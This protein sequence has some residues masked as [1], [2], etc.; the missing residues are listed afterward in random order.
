[1]DQADQ[2]HQPD[3]RADHPD[4]AEQVRDQDERQRSVDR[5]SSLLSLQPGRAALGARA[6]PTAATC[7]GVRATRSR[8]RRRHVLVLATLGA[9]ERRRLKAIRKRSK[10]EPEPEPTPVATVPGDDHRR[11]QPRSRAAPRRRRGSIAPARTSWRPIWPSSTA[12][13]TRSGSPRPIRTSTRVGRRQA[14]V[15][16]VGLRRRR[17]GRRRTVDRRPRAG[18][19][20]GPAPARAR[21]SPPRL[22]SPRSSTAATAR[23][24]ARS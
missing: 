5:A 10:A 21:C 19:R 11:R 20:V 9:R 24:R 13:C 16:R 1:M 18:A 7:S 6:R 23:S 15:A 4:R 14:L 22:V 2:P 17:G 12:R 3:P 8:P